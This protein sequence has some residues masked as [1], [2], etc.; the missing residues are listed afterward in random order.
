METLTGPGYSIDE[1]LLRYR[2]ELTLPAEARGD[3]R[4]A[5]RAADL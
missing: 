2:Y 1:D 4:P 3:R 5:R